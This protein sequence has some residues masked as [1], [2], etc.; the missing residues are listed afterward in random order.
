MEAG[1]SADSDS[2]IALSGNHSLRHLQAWAAAKQDHLSHAASAPIRIRRIGHFRLF[3]LRSLQPAVESRN[4]RAG[5]LSIFIGHG[6]LTLSAGLLRNLR[7]ELVRRKALALFR[8]FA[9][10]R[11]INC[12]IKERDRIR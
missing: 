8:L 12:L 3:D 9:L 6:F 4:I 7:A 5:T 1:R 11:L 2:T 10:F